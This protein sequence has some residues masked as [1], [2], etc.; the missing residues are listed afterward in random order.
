FGRQRNIALNRWRL[1]LS[2]YNRGLAEIAA[3]R[4]S[5]LHRYLANHPSAGDRPEAAR[6]LIVIRIWPRNVYNLHYSWGEFGAQV[7]NELDQ[8]V[9]DYPNSPH[10]GMAA[11]YRGFVAFGLRSENGSPDRPWGKND[12]LA[13]DRALAET[14]SNYAGST[15]GGLALAWRL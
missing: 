14:A 11:L 6:N 4:I 13:L 3:R 12:I 10:A 9:R 2:D 8:F 15:P 1:P 7:L 5:A